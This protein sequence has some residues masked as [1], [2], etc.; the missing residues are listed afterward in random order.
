MSSAG[1]A[2]GA[3]SGFTRGEV[4]A[5]R[6][7]RSFAGRGR[8]VGFAVAGM[9][10]LDEGGLS[11]VATVPGSDM[12]TRAGAGGGPRGRI[13]PDGEWDG[14]YDDLAWR[15]DTVVRVHRA[16]AEWSVWRWH[17][18]TAWSPHWYGNLEAPWR[19]G[20]NGFDTQ[21]W[22]LDVVASGA[23]GGADWSVAYKDEDELAWFEAVGAVDAGQAAHI[24]GAGRRLTEVAVRG[25]W[26]FDA[27]WDR[28]I[29][30]P[31]WRAATL[32]DGWD[33]VS[34]TAPPDAIL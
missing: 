26:P 23:V 7:I 32:P 28:W 1:G 4:V 8:A 9:V 11:V 19:R 16:G 12:R 21:D 10:V 15:G 25:D 17:D 33:I 31:A 34:G 24:R 27:D 5:L 22:A 3:G 13:V 20:P 30:D 29:P 2:E 18:G 14:T 6:S